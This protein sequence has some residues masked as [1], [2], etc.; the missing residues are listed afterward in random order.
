MFMSNISFDDDNDKRIY[1]EL[2]RKNRGLARI[3]SKL[4]T[5]NCGI[6]LEK[7]SNIEN[8][9]SLVFSGN[10]VDDTYIY[11]DLNYSNNKIY[12]GTGGMMYQEE[13]NNI[14]VLNMKPNGLL[15]KNNER[16]IYKEL[17]YKLSKDN[18]VKYYRLNENGN[19]YTIVLDIINDDFN[20]DDFIYNLLYNTAKYNRIRDLFIIIN[21]NVNT[22]NVNFKLADSKGSN[23]V[24]ENGRII[25]YLECID[26]ETETL[27]VY[28]EDGEFYYERMI[29][30]SYK[31]N[32]TE[33]VKKL[34]EG[35]GKKER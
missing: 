9:V 23:I 35:H 1:Q 30:E 27:K 31:D 26:N 3:I 33:Y 10:I 15:Y 21:E 34:G 11:V 29:K 32:L 6:K 12:V 24:L 4:S 25:N 7:I 18:N 17:K 22:N 16:E 13:Y 8:S 28:M 20:E 19:N 2:I 5:D 14:P